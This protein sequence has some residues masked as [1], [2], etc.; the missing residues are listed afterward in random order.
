LKNTRFTEQRPLCGAAGVRPCAYAQTVF[1]EKDRTVAVRSSVW[2][3]APWGT[4]ARRRRAVYLKKKRYRLLGR[5]Y[6]HAHGR[7]RPHRPQ[8]DLCVFVEVKLR[9]SAAFAEAR[10]FV[11]GRKAG[12]DYEGRRRAGCRPNPTTLHAAL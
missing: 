6:R 5:N 12:T 2:M 1:F 4:S 10:E 8:R 11:T 9:R 7:S 3:R